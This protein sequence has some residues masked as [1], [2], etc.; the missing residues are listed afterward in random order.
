MKD[1]WLSLDANKDFNT[2]SVSVHTHC[3]IYSGLLL[4][5]WG[6]QT[7][8]DIKALKHNRHIQDMIT[9]GQF[10]G[11]G[12]S[13]MP[14]S[15]WL[16]MLLTTNQWLK[17]YHKGICLNSMKTN[18]GRLF[19]SPTFSLLLEKGFAL[20]RACHL[21]TIKGENVLFILAGAIFSL[22]DLFLK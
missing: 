11:K 22:L 15:I 17:C 14:R 10:P 13:N 9:P 7:T 8:E 19:L 21:Y 6:L 12:R 3:F 18:S 2:V 20:G 4:D 1:K 5:S 16:M